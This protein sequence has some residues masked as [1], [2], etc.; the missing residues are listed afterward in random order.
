[1]C[2]CVC[3]KE[4]SG[5][6]AGAGVAAAAMTNGEFSS[7]SSSSTRPVSYSSTR[8]ADAVGAYAAGGSGLVSSAYNSAP[9]DNDPWDDRSA[10]GHTGSASE[11]STAYLY[12]SVVPPSQRQP[13][14]MHSN[15]L[16]EYDVWV[17]CFM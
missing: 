13:Q 14:S 15:D 4:Y 16:Q 6:P 7:S 2:V 8:S 9:A 10:S 3:V 1:M 12:S 5:E 17:S 11:T